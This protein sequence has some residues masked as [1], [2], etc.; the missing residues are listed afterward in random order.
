MVDNSK[1]QQVLIHLGEELGK[2]LYKILTNDNGK[3]GEFKLSYFEMRQIMQYAN[4]MCIGKLYDDEN[5][6]ETRGELQNESGQNRKKE[7]G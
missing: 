2:S 5:P 3:Y 7:S 6:P 1:R 4:N